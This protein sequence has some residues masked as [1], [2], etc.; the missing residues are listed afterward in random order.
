MGDNAV[1]ENTPSVEDNGVITIMEKAVNFN[2]SECNSARDSIN[3][4]DTSNTEDGGVVLNV[5]TPIDSEDDILDSFC[6]SVRIP[7]YTRSCSAI[8][9]G[10][11]STISEEDDSKDNIRPRKESSGS[12]TSDTR[13]ATLSHVSLDLTT[14]GH[15]RNRKRDKLRRGLRNLTAV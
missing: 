15:K 11:S 6:D 1:V 14:M 13:P 9:I 12:G 10:T 8:T 5:E 7:A 3:M 4:E 2:L